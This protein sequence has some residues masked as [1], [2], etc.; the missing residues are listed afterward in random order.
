MRKEKIIL[1]I[2]ILLSSFYPARFLNEIARAENSSSLDSI[3]NIQNIVTRNTPDFI[4]KPITM[5]ANVID[6]FRKQ[7][8]FNNKLVFYG[9]LAVIIFFLVRFI[10]RRIF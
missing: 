7:I 3:Q 5:T 6:G 2:F 1:V 4:A 10:W 8:G 9:L